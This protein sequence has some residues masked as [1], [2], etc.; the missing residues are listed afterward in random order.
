MPESVKAVAE[1]AL[2]F[3]VAAANGNG[4]QQVN[5]NRMLEAVII[6]GILALGGYLMII[7]TLETKL[8]AISAEV[9]EIGQDLKTVKADVVQLKIDTAVERARHSEAPHP[10]P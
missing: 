5:V 2:P 6:A 4:A 7:P 9:H 3:M 10:T 8:T 1:H